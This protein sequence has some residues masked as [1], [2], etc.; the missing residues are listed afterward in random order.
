VDECKHL[1]GI[2]RLRLYKYG[3]LL[4]SFPFKFKLRRYTKGYKTVFWG[5]RKNWKNIEG[6]EAGAYTRPLFSST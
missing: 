1:P 6:T 5:T 4:S 3:E 2:R